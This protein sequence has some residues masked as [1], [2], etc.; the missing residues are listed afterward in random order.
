MTRMNGIL[1]DSDIQVLVN[2]GTVNAICSFDKDQIQPA[3]LDLRLGDKAYRIRASFMPGSSAT[4]IDKLERLKLYEFDLQD[5]AVLETGC[6]YIVPLLENLALSKVLS[7]VA[8]PKSS[9]GRLDVFTRVISDY[10]QEFDKIC[11]GYHGPLYLE[12]SPRTFPI[13]VRTGSRL[14]QLRF[15]KGHSYLKE[16]ELYE[17]HKNEMLVSDDTPNINDGGIGISVNLEGNENGLVGYRGKRHT[18][19]IDVD[20]SAVA[21]ILDFWEPIYDHGT[22]EIVLD[23]HEFYILVSR[24]VIHI[25]PF[26]AAEMK[27]FDPLIGEFRVHYAGFFDPGFGNMEISRKGARAVLEVRNHEIPF[28]LEHGQIIGRLVYEHMLNRPLKLYGHDVG[29]HYQGQGLKLSKHFK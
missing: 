4:V 16:V 11:M 18:D 20:K 29:S 8:N 12:I 7:A 25:P 14:S 5:G 13:L 28:I 27:P 10:T 15:R 17:L 26:Y 19:V 21:H 1:A 23:P 22:K 9:T 3:S 2:N 6:V 24:E